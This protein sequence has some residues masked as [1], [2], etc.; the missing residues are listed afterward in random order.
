[1]TASGSSRKPVRV[2]L[3]CMGVRTISRLW[4]LERRQNEVIERGVVTLGVRH[5]VLKCAKV[6]IAIFGASEP[7]H[8]SQRPNLEHFIV[9]GCVTILNPQSEPRGIWLS[10]DILQP[11]D[12]VQRAQA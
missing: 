5:G 3:V 12:A 6:H 7:A 10:C 9:V 11:R 2:L 4:K 8:E 1:M